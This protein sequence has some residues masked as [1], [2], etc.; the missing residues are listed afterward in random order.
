VIESRGLY[1]FPGRG[2]FATRCARI[3]CGRTATRSVIGT[4]AD[5]AAAKPSLN[6]DVAA[7]AARARAACSAR[8]DV[9]RGT[10]VALFRVRPRTRWTALYTATA[11]T[12]RVR[13]AI[14]AR[15]REAVSWPRPVSARSERY[16]RRWVVRMEAARAPRLGPARSGGSS[17][18]YGRRGVMGA[19]RS[20][21]EP[22]GG[23]APSGVLQ[24]YARP[25]RVLKK[26]SSEE[27]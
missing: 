21:L 19:T 27:K 9:A 12:G 4:R 5:A 16:W 11:S 2:D 3:G 1:E 14:S 8:R 18:E 13:R 22:R 26:G 23:A 25:A 10:R 7:T 6:L 20:G 17:G 15:A 24:A